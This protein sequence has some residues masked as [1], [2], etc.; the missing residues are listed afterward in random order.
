MSQAAGS[1]DFWMK[2]EVL[3]SALTESDNV[4]VEILAYQKTYPQTL[5]KAKG[6]ERYKALMDI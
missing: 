4:K 5:G 6:E 2:A 3:Q 1:F